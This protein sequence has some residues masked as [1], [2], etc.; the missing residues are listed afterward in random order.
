M[1][2][3]GEDYLELDRPYRKHEAFCCWPSKHLTPS[4]LVDVP[5]NAVPAREFA[6]IILSLWIPSGLLS[7]CKAGKL[8]NHRPMTP[9]SRNCCLEAGLNGRTIFARVH[10]TPYTVDGHGHPN[11]KKEP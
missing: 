5:V 10:Q 9:V 7:V 2:Y 4:L 11:F 8:Q 3:V 6:F 1:Q